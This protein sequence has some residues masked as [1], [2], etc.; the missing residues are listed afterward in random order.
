MQ[1][2]PTDN[3]QHAVLLYFKRVDTKML[4]H[5]VWVKSLPQILLISYNSMKERIA[6]KIYLHGLSKSPNMLTTCILDQANTDINKKD[7]K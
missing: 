1:V 4:Q 3:I 5:L 7:S 2:H 6:D